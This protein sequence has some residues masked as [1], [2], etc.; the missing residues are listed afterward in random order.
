[1]KHGYTASDYAGQTLAIAT[2]AGA[3]RL[4]L[5]IDYDGAV[6]D[7]VKSNGRPRHLHVA[8]RNHLYLFYPER[9]LVAVIKRELLPPGEVVIE[10]PI[11]GHFFRLLPKAEVSRVQAKRAARK[12]ARPKARRR[13]ARAAP[14][15]APRAASPGSGLSL[16]SFDLET[17]VARFREPMSAA[18]AG[19]SGWRTATLAD[20]RRARVARFGKTE[21]R[22]QP[23]VVIASTPIKGLS[24]SVSSGARL[25]Y[26]RVNRAVFGTRAH[27]ISESVARFVS[28][29]AADPSGKTRVV[30]RV[31]G[32]TVSVTRDTGR[33]LLVYGVYAD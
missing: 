2:P 25:G 10:T 15:A 14:P 22:V 3:E 6:R 7:F 33:G 26:V 8:D 19:V 30:R 13:T 31:A 24:R 1:V 32:R 21:Y 18:D 23:D 5:E 12:A 29:V 28:Q 16:N 27:S 9:D 17:M 4:Q 11:P 20:G